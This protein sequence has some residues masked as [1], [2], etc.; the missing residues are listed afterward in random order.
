MPRLRCLWARYRAIDRRAPAPGPGCRGSP[1][2][3]RANVNL[4]RGRCR[5][6]S[7]TADSQ[8]SFTGPRPRCPK[9]A[10]RAPQTNRPRCR[11]PTANGQMRRPRCRVPEPQIG[12]SW[13]R[14]RAGPVPTSPVPLRCR[15]RA[16]W[17]GISRRPGPADGGWVPGVLRE[18]PAPGAGSRRPDRRAAPDPPPAEGQAPGAG[19]GPGAGAGAGP[20]AADIFRPMPTVGLAHGT[21]HQ[22]TADTTRLWREPRRRVLAPLARG[23]TARCRG[24]A[25]HAQSHNGPLPKVRSEPRYPCRR[26]APHGWCQNPRRQDLRRQNPW[27]LGP[28]APRAGPFKGRL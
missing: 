16:P 21:P 6:P 15:G 22:M 13:H 1:G 5:R 25:H 9:Q 7:A 28:R 4:G 19:P 17:T 20:G 2:A 26:P 18:T 10:S 24:A 11:W 27:R 23:S 14:V 3:A 8:A 12:P